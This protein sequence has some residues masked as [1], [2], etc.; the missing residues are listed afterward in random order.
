VAFFGYPGKPSLLTNEPCRITELASAADDIEAALDALAAEIGALNVPA[1]QI[2]AAE[3]PAVPKGALTPEGIAAVIGAH[4][5]ENCIVVDES[6]TAGRGFAAATAG[7]PPHDWLG[8]MGGSIGFGLPNGVGAAVAAPDR[9]VIVLEGDGS[10]M[11]TIQALWT[12]ARNALDITVVVFANRSYQILR[13]ELAGV[14]AGEPGRNATDMLMID[15]PDLDWVSLA[16]GQG[17][18]AGRATNLEELAREF[19]RGV[20]IKGPYLIEVVM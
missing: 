19:A 9:K 1:A 8:I 5:P 3:R 15:R 20:A 13:G 14:G 10:G 11:Y 6:I 16:K 2:A 7:V 17:V 18:E 4:M 12:M